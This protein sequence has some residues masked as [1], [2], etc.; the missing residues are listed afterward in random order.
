VPLPLYLDQDSLTAAVV[1]GLRAGGIDVLT[2][3]EAGQQ[4][5][6]DESQ[7]LFALSTGRMLYTGNRRDFGRIHRDW[8]A[9]ARE[10]AGIIVRSHQFTGIPEQ[11]RALISICTALED[12]GGTNRFIYLES[13]LRSV[14]ADRPA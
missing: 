7:L 13:W 1:A 12:D 6:S 14:S 8:M 3:H 10:H 9:T 2:S 5:L 11:T 4:R